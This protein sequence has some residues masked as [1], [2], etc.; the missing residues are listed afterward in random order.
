VDFGFTEK[1]EQWRD[2][3]VAFMEERVL[4]AEEVYAAQ[5]R[6]AGDPHGDPPILEE[7][8][9][10]ARSRG[11][12]NLFLPDDRWGAGLSV[13]EYAPLAE[14]TGWSPHLAPEALNCS[15]PDTGNMEILAMFGTPEQ[16]E[17]WLA[18]LLDGEIRS[19]FSMTEPD[20]AS[21]D[22][23]NIRCRIERD[24]D[25][26]VITG[27][28]WWS[29][30]ALSPRCRLSIVMG[31][32]NPDADTYR[33]QSMVLV[34][35]DTP[36]VRIVRNVPVFGYEERGGHAEIAFEGARVPVANLLGDEGGGFSIAQERLGPGRIHHCMRLIGMAERAFEVMAGRAHERVAFGKPLAAQGV[37][38]DWIAEA[39]IRIE[40]ARLLVLKTAWLIDTVGPKGARVEVAAIKVVAPRT[41]MWVIDRGMQVLGGAGVS[42]DFPLAR[43]YAGARSLAIADGPDE[44]HMR[45]VARRELRRFAPQ[46]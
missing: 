26:Y 3:L 8:K 30:G 24:G 42:D 18:P 23:T 20:V 12:W 11:L 4:P 44:V 22:A 36:G 35:M 6:E 38:Q 15:A 14:I 2:R 17:R 29:S 13:L 5:M 9:A 1:M 37:V 34:P 31:V 43:L 39:R 33:R 21:S 46:A 41:A 45:S 32:T 25:E 19:C 40:Q 28:K 27:R 7:L 10:E 16:Q